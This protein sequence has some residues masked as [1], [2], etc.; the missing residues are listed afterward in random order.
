MKHYPLKYLVYFQAVWYFTE[1]S[2]TSLGCCI[3]TQIRHGRRK[4]QS[5][6]LPCENRRRVSASYLPYPTL[7]HLAISLIQTHQFSVYN[8]VVFV[9]FMSSSSYAQYACR[10]WFSKHVHMIPFPAVISYFYILF[11]VICSVTFEVISRQQ[12]FR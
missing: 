10:A 6:G 5:V 8:F 1:V 3:K 2:N 12:D 4:Y 11:Y 9:F 7:T